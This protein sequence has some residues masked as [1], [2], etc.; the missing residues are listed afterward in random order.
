MP[1]PTTK[2]TLSAKERIL[3]MAAQKP[4]ASS[5]DLST[6]ATPVYNTNKPET[7]TTKEKEI[8][9]SSQAEAMRQRAALETDYTLPK[10]SDP[11]G[12]TRLGGSAPSIEPERETPQALRN[13]GESLANKWT[14]GATTA[15]EANRAARD[16]SIDFLE[17]IPAAVQ[18]GADQF[19]TGVTGAVDMLLGQPLQALGW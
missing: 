16:T 9:I 10:A 4:V 5:A 12:T 1:K 19:Y 2:S 6:R 7:Q 17:A 11:P 3:N 18:R 13:L 15:E 14:K 8:D